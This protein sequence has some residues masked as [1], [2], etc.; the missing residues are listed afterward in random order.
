MARDYNNMELKDI[1]GKKNCIG[2]GLSRIFIN[3]EDHEPPEGDEE[4]EKVDAYSNQSLVLMSEE[5]N[6]RRRRSRGICR[7]YTIT[8]GI[9]DIGSSGERWR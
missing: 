9:G 6:W 5:D 3:E 4:V 8:M 2:D 7:G 1:A